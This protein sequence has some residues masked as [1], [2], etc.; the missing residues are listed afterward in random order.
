MKKNILLLH[1]WNYKNYSSMTKEQDAWHNRKSLVEKLEK[2]YNIYKLNFPGF[3]Q[4]TEPKEKMWTLK[5]YASYV[6]DYLNKNSLKIDYII[7]YS[8]GGAVAITYNRIYKNDQKLILIS[9]AI[10]RENKKSKSF[11]KTPSFLNPL[12]N[13]IRDLY[14][15]YIV[16][17]NE[18][19]YGSKF[20]RRSYQSIVRVDLLDSLEKID[21]KLIN[22]IYGSE[23]EMVKPNYVV[24]NTSKRYKNCFHL[25]SDGKHDIGN[26][27]VDEVINIIDSVIK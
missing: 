24:K 14:L 13:K 22:I 11:L 16:K 27:H 25:I 23:D 17:T 4:A 7:G 15:I 8:F 9:P 10:V 19:V 26:T 5:D 2:K 20:L 1:G 3:C 21:P 12:R 18:M 6:K